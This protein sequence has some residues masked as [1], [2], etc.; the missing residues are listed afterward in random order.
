MSRN[1]NHDEAA[2]LY[3]QALELYRQSLGDEHPEIAVVI[4]NLAITT[5]RQGNLE[6][7]EELF[8]ETLA[9]QRRLLG[10][11]SSTV[12]QTLYNLGS[13]LVDRGSHAEAETL[14]REAVTIVEALY[15]SGD[16]ASVLTVGGLAGALLAKGDPEAAENLLRE[17]MASWR[18]KLEGSWFLAAGESFL[19]ESLL[20]QGRYSE[21]EPFLEAGYAGLRDQRGEAFP[22]T[23]EALARLVELYERWGKD[24]L[25]RRYRSLQKS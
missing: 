5:K 21:A 22:R 14:L 1:G 2:Q 13:L 10:D 11:D 9:L 6:G 17:R 12:G 3:R 7:A 8:R 19:G 20:A 18:Q 4:N 24:D 25:A 16:Y 15:G 23:R